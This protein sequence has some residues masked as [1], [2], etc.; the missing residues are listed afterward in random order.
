[1][2]QRIWVEKSWPA[3]VPKKLVYRL[4]E[5]PLHEYLRANAAEMP[6]RVAYIYYGREITWRQLDR[7]SDNIA[8]FLLSKGVQKGDRVALFMQNCPQYIIAH[9]ALQKIG[10][11]V[12]PASPMFK[13]W[14]LEYEV[15]DMGAKA[16]F[17]SDDLYPVVKKILDKTDLEL[18]VLTNY[19]DFAPGEP[20][21]PVPAELTQEKK[22]FPGTYDL[23]D[24]LN[25]RQPEVPRIE[26]D[27]WEDV[28]LMVYT[29]G[30]TGRPKGA[31]LTYGK[32]PF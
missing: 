5:K 25:S 27:L 14:E 28:A 2:V 11:I 9:Y 29:S 3:G 19:A 20:S 22:R 21:I 18:V 1:L 23:M 7:Y 16:I 32:R 6:D 30:S 24:L 13:E 26:V 8:G 31:M 12:G 17:A 4:G 10:A 15:N